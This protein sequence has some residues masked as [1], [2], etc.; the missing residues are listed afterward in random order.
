MILAIDPALATLGWAVVEPRTGRVIELGV[1]LAPANKRAGVHE[2]RL[3]RA[4]AHAAALRAI[5][6][7]YGCTRIESEALSLPRR[8]GVNAWASVFLTWGMLVGLAS[9]LALPRPR[10]IQPKQWQR[11]VVPEEELRAREGYA[12]IERALADFVRGQPAA[13]QLAAIAPSN[14]NHALDAAGVG[15]FAALRPAEAE[16]TGRRRR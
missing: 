12:A 5:A 13:E 11:A 14:R 16:V 15:V 9:G 2:D 4:D 10:Q 3:Q 1:R 6:I 8:G 7:R